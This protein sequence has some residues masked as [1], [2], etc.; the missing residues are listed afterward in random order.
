VLTLT[1]GRI[2]SLWMVADEL[3]ALAQVGAVAL[4]APASVAASPG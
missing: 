2:S 3:G 1:E 4:V